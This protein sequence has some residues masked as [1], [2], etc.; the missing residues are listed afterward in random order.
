MQEIRKARRHGLQACHLPGHPTSAGLSSSA[1]TNKHSRNTFSRHRPPAP[2]LLSSN[3][4]HNQHLTVTTAYCQPLATAIAPTHP[5]LGTMPKNSTTNSTTTCQG[6]GESNAHTNQEQSRASGANYKQSPP[7]NKGV[8]ISQKY[9]ISV[10]LL[11][12]H[13][14]AAAARNESSS[15]HFE[16]EAIFLPIGS[17]YVQSSWAHVKI[18]IPVSTIIFEAKAIWEKLSPVEENGDYSLPLQLFADRWRRVD[19]FTA[20]NCET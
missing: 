2:Q 15:N 1:T 12:L 10:I 3:K 14:C 19:L 4:K 8:A 7:Q 16:A 17:A 6:V 9:W 11:T 13:T 5:G 20:Q 18:F